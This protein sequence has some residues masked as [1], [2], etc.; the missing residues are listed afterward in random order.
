[1]NETLNIDDFTGAGHSAVRQR[2]PIGRDRDIF[3]EGVYKHHVVESAS[4]PEIGST[5]MSKRPALGVLTS[6]WVGHSDGEFLTCI[7]VC[8]SLGA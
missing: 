5:S 4:R 7:Q 2:H 8:L 3:Q 1:M 6:V